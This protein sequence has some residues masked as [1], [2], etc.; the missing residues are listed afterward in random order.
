VIGQTIS[1]YRIVEKLGGGGMGVVYKA[2]DVKLSRFVALKFLPDV[3][4][5]DPQALARFQREAKAASALNHPNICTIY[6]I[7]DQ[8]GEAFIAMEF[9][10]G[11]TLKHRMA[12]RPMETELIL[13]LAIE[14][15]DALDAAHSQGIIHR[16]IKPANIFVTKR[17][18][19]KILDFG[20]AKVTQPMRE[21]GSEAAGQTT[22][23][24]EE[25]LTSPGATVGTVAY[26][27]PEQVRTKEL[28]SRTDLFSFGAVLYEMATGQLP[29]QGESSGV[30]FKAILDSDPPPVI[31]FNREI[32]AKLEEIINR[33]LEKDRELRYQSANEMRA[34]LQRLKRDTESGRATASSGTVPGQPAPLIAARKRFGVLAMT[35]TLV[36]AALIAGGVYYRLPRA[37]LLKEKDTI[38]LTDFDNKTGDPAFDDAMKQ[39]LAVQLEQSP[40]LSVLPDSRLQDTL[41]LMG[42]PPN[43]RVT[44]E[45]AREIC[46]RAGSKAY[47]TGA[48]AGLGN[49]YPITLNL[50][51]CQTG[52]S[53]AHEQATAAGKEQVLNKLSEAA[54]KLRGKAGESLSS[55][56]KFD[57]P[58]E[59]AATPSLEALKS[60]SLGM[61]V[62]SEKGPAE[63]IP[64]F[65]QAIERDPNFASAYASLASCYGN[66]GEVDLWH[67]NIGKAYELR[68]RASEREKLRISNMYFFDRG[69]LEKALE[70]TRLWAE[71]YP[72]DKTAHVDLAL[73]YAQLGQHEKAVREQEEAVRLD[74]DDLM[75][76]LQLISMYELVNRFDEAKA[77]WQKAVARYPMDPDLH[78]GRYYLA[79]LESDAA[80][81][82]RQVA[83][84]SD[85]PG[86]DEQFLG[87]T[88]PI[89]E[90][91][92]RLSKAQE[93]RRRLIALAVQSNRKETAAEQ[94]LALSWTEADYGY[95]EPAR[96]GT[97]AA[98]AESSALSVQIGAAVVLARA[99]DPIRAEAIARDLEKRFPLDTIFRIHTYWL[100]TIRAAIALNRNN[101][102]E[103]IQ[104][105]Q[106]TSQY[107]LFQGGG[108]Y[109]GLYAVY[110]RGAAYLLQHQGGA[111]ALEFQKILD[112]RGLVGSSS[113]G[114][115]AHLGLARAYL[116]A[117]DTL[118]AKAAYQDFLTLWKDADPDIPILKQANAEYA[119][120]VLSSTSSGRVKVPQAPK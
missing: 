85:K 67:E 36:A 4:A 5:K 25:H 90:F 56:Q 58:I 89:D 72:K 11:V 10:D 18:H 37:T 104:F 93:L 49:E 81:M 114:A 59:Q 63:A 76:C 84:A 99:G 97:L 96:R 17:G 78:V 34:E 65:K 57:V 95:S 92:G 115:L 35:A 94:Q 39:G 74:P 87:T 101:P 41:K 23:T 33:A 117:G 100:P 1:H 20:L 38:V 55:V 108:L 9:L 98:L 40:F 7:D 68:D 71:E 24:L 31:R 19:A 83:W 8:H 105:L 30:I 102:A 46:Q 6:E 53:I 77:M 69:E 47:L 28:D 22:V 48:I 64:F 82:A 14:I 113:Q 119:K 60:Y 80:E 27:S 42:R 12:G 66:S 52:D 91:Y 16:D 54:R 75:E 61:K 51:N 29:Y 86:A 3:V 79:F 109:G 88:A 106:A 70:A 118:R 15:A 73:T 120:C 32:P 44:A 50:V 13:S 107:D 43:E 26:M 62:R 116:I 45:L 2:E 112:H 103:A 21:P 110:L 111:A